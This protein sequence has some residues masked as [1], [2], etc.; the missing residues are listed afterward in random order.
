M[1]LIDDGIIRKL[2]AQDGHKLTQKECNEDNRIFTPEAY[3]G[4][5]DSIDNYLEWNDSA[6]EEWES[7]HKVKQDE[8]Q[9]PQ[10]K[11]S[12]TSLLQKLKLNS[13]K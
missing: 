13:N 10:P 12:I 1:E 5:N 9:E 11:M 6:V 7:V 3:L 2:I 4:V 8:T